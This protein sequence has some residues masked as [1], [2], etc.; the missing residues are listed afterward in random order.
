MGSSLETELEPR[1][2]ELDDRTITLTG[3]VDGQY[4][5]W[6]DLLARMYAAERGDQPIQQAPAEGS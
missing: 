5:Q 2:I 3:T 1:V 6:K 4:A